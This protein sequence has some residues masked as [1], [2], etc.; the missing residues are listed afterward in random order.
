MRMTMEAD[1]QFFWYLMAT[2]IWI[3][4]EKLDPHVVSLSAFR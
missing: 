4:E 3:S 1:T 2:H